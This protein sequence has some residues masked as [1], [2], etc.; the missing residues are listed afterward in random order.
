[1]LCY[2]L[3]KKS[4]IKSLHHHSTPLSLSF[5]LSL[6]SSWRLHKTWGKNGD[7]HFSLT[8]CYSLRSCILAGQKKLKTA[9]KENIM[10]TKHSMPWISLPSFSLSLHFPFLFI[11]PFS[12]FSLSLHS[13]FLFILPFSSFHVC[14]AVLRKSCLLI[15]PAQVFP[16]K[17]SFSENHRQKYIF[18]FCFQDGEESSLTFNPKSTCELQVAIRVHSQQT[19]KID[20]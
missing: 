14:L 15:F 20:Q 1:M 12:S 6:P 5:S 4:N 11:F 19:S 16:S 7:I 2:A 9:L 3:L 10:N 13:P 17:F 8:F 18:S